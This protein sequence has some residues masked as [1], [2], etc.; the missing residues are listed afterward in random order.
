MTPA[1]EP[2][3]TYTHAQVEAMLNGISSDAAKFGLEVV[4][5]LNG[6]LGLRAAPSAS[7]LAPP[8]SIERQGDG[9][10]RITH[11]ER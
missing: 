7:M 3:P 4:D 9:S 5:Y 6:K 1:I 11:D 2:P 8:F 10:F